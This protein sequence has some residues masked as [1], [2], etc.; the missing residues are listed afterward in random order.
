MRA[1]TAA[2]T[3]SS[4]V[5]AQTSR[6]ANCRKARANRRVK[7]NCRN[8]NARPEMRPTSN[9]RRTHRGQRRSQAERSTTCPFASF[10]RTDAVLWKPSSKPSSFAVPPKFEMPTDFP[11]CWRGRKYFHRDRF[12]TLY[13]CNVLREICRQVKQ[14]GFRSKPHLNRNMAG[15]SRFQGKHKGVWKPDKFAGSFELFLVFS[16]VENCKNLIDLYIL[17]P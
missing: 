6:A 7:G 13:S 4:L 17:S 5:L 2:R 8:C 16:L 1:R 15:F 14:I 10:D 3:V 11:G 9:K 12:V